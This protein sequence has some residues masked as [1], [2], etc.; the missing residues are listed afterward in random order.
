MAFEPFDLGG[1]G[2]FGVFDE[3]GNPS[4]KFYA[5]RAEALKYAAVLKAAFQASAQGTGTPG[6][7]IP[8]AAA[9]A[10]SRANP[11]GA[12]SAG[13]SRAVPL[14]TGFAQA[15]TFSTPPTG[16][17]VN[18]TTALGGVASASP[19]S[20]TR[21]ATGR[22]PLADAFE[23]A[24]D[25]SIGKAIAGAEKIVTGS[26]TAF[27]S[28][29]STVKSAIANPGQG[30]AAFGSSVNRAAFGASVVAAFAAARARG[31]FGVGV[32]GIASAPG[33]AV[34][35][36]AAAFGRA[37]KVGRS[38][39]KAARRASRQAQ[40]YRN[41]ARSRLAKSR[42]VRQGVAAVFGTNTASQLGR[43][44][45]T[46][47]IG[48][49]AGALVSATSAFLKF[50]VATA[51]NS[52]E[53]NRRLIPYSGKISMG[54]AQLAYGDQMRDLRLA[55]S[56]EG[57]ALTLARQVNGIREGLLGMDELS[58]GLGNRLGIAAAALVG[59]G[60]RAVGDLAGGVAGWMNKIDPDGRGVASVFD[61]LHESIAGAAGGLG[62][63]FTGVGWD[64]GKKDA[65]D[66]AIA[67]RRRG[68][69]DETDLWTRF[70]TNAMSIP[71]GRP[72]RPVKK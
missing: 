43:N 31:L 39:G 8:A 33:M 68:M 36:L 45:V 67:E 46:R 23:R 28:G 72:A 38:S 20:A 22:G 70:M 37:R 1:G 71:V 24:F 48:L 7:S 35:G 17:T 40:N 61:W 13:S 10:A 41:S 11:G 53:R 27:R 69:K 18:P 42:V 6:R 63:W 14:P 16:S 64:K 60:V 29:F 21:S 9:Q 50:G 5:T 59:P 25:A 55:K 32:S 51:E 3:N 49:A 19:G 65:I 2:G 15:S 34:Q 62:G 44:V 30:A 56:A 12:A 52:L 54:F 57:T 47:D 66:E 58:L 26:L 4:P